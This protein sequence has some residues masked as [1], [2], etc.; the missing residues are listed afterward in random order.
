MNTSAEHVNKFMMNV[1]VMKP[2]QYVYIKIINVS[3]YC[4]ILLLILNHVIRHR[5]VNGVKYYNIVL[6]HVNRL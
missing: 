4:V 5:D 3:Q 1:N 6:C 2:N